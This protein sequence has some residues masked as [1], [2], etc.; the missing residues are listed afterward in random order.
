MRPRP[1][2]LYSSVF[3]PSSKLV[4]PAVAVGSIATAVSCFAVIILY[5]FPGI[6]D[7]VV[8][9]IVTVA[10][11]IFPLITSIIIRKHVWSPASVKKVVKES[12]ELTLEEEAQRRTTKLATHPRNLPSFAEIKKMNEEAEKEGHGIS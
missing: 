4:E 5:F 9:S 10:A 3:D 12:E 8:N 1:T 2:R 6:P 11:I 7:N